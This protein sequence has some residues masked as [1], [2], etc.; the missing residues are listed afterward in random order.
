MLTLEECRRIDPSVKNL[1]NEELTKLRSELYALI[2]ILFDH[3]LNQERLA[4]QPLG[5]N[6][7]LGSCSE[8]KD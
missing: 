1:T 6:I 8:A 7:L 3:W 5:S 2:D 4:N